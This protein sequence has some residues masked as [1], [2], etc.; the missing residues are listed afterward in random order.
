MS[1]SDAV[2]ITLGTAK[3]KPYTA[4]GLEP[5]STFNAVAPPSQVL[6]DVLIVPDTAPVQVENA[7]SSVPSKLIFLIARLATDNCIFRG[8]LG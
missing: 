3:K 2:S 8:I 5:E 1:S 6:D 7:P 4:N